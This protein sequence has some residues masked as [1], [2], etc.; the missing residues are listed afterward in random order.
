MKI[1]SDFIQK[2][3]KCAVINDLINELGNKGF[4]GLKPISKY[5][6]FHT[7][8]IFYATGGKYNLGTALKI[9]ISGNK[10]QFWWNISVDWD[11]SL[12]S[13]RVTKIIASKLL[14]ARFQTYGSCNET[15]TLGTFID[16]ANEMKN[17]AILIKKEM[18][19]FFVKYEEE[20]KIY[21]EKINKE[22]NE[23]STHFILAQ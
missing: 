18:E 13:V 16:V 11:N 5:K 1:I 17:Q 21:Q 4:H 6:D 22:I 15:S 10:H 3:F 14:E 19:D 23:F 7:E 12:G 20:I 8:G 2:R 9:S